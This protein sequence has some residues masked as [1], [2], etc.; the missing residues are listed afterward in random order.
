MKYE[1]GN[2]KYSRLNEKTSCYIN[3]I[4]R[5][6]DSELLHCYLRDLLAEAIRME[7]TLTHLLKV[8]S[9][10]SIAESDSKEFIDNVSKHYA[11]GITASDKKRDTQKDAEESARKSTLISG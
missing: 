4:N 11:R 5:K 3:A 2:K 7:I 10:S 6:D 1:K 8:F 9:D